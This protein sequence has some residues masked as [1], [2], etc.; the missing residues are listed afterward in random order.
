MG[1]NVTGQKSTRRRTR[2]II[3]LDT[4]RM[5]PYTFRVEA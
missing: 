2:I 4:L 5:H 1:Q 3:Q